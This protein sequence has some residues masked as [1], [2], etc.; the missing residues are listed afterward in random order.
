MFKGVNKEDIFNYYKKVAKY[1]LP[2]I[3][4]RLISTVRIPN[5]INGEKFFKKHFSENKYLYKVRGNYYYIDDEIGLLSEVQNNSIEFHIGCSIINS[6]Y[7]NIMV[8][9]LDPDENL[10]INKIRQGVKDLK[11]ILKAKM[12]IH[13]T[14]LKMQKIKLVMLRQ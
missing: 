4:N 6:R 9:D 5:G 2:Y 14:N 3:K 8:F 13:L 1:M 11:K 12:N 7:P 10:S